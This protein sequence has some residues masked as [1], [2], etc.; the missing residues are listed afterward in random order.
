MYM[1]KV[2]SHLITEQL[3]RSKN[4]VMNKLRKKDNKARNVM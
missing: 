1:N 3:I 4:I 2:N